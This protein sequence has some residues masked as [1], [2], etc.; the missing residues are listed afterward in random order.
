M[1]RCFDISPLPALGKVNHFDLYFY[2]PA[3]TQQLFTDKR[4]QP[5]R[6]YSLFS[7]VYNATGR[8]DL[9]ILQ[10]FHA[11]GLVLLQSL[12]TFALYLLHMC[13]MAL[14]IQTK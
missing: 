11:V 6:H 14:I 13:F 12:L 5:A 3:A 2:L 4:Q 1:F 7:F 8:H 9:C 10:N